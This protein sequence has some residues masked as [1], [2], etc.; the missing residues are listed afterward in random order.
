MFPSFT[1]GQAQADRD[2]ARRARRLADTQTDPAEKARLRRYAEELDA[3][4]ARREREGRPPVIPHP[5]NE[6]SAAD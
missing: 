3:Q 5:A 6:F 2:L 4:A 1:F